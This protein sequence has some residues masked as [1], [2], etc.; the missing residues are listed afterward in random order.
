M[1]R[2][3]TATVPYNAE[4]AY[5]AFVYGV[6]I[7]I[8]K[9]DQNGQFIHF[10]FLFGKVMV[11][12]YYFQSA[13]FRRAYIVSCDEKNSFGKRI[14]LPGFNQPVRLIYLARGRA[15]YHL[16]RIMMFL[17]QEHPFKVFCLPTIFWNRLSN[18]IQY[19]NG[20][21]SDVNWLVNQ[22]NK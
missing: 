1:I 13:K 7:D 19:K 2:T 11:I 17:T 12:F 14:E 5:K 16:R 4:I 20:K 6:K 21:M 15:F 3:I 22:Y 10:D 8:P 18:I 9:I